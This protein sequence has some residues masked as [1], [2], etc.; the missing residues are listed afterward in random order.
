MTD[1]PTI[2]Q[3]CHRIA[4]LLRGGQGRPSENLIDLLADA[5][6]W[7]DY[8]AEYFG[9]LDRQAYQRYIAEVDASREERQP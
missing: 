9:E 6:H 2:R 7:C 3:R 8:N 1:E 4:R 5:R